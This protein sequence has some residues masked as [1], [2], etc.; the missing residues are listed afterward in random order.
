MSSF[1]LTNHVTRLP[2]IR[3]LGRVVVVYVLSPMFRDLIVTVP[4]PIVVSL[5][6]S[7]QNQNTNGALF[8]R[9]TIPLS[10]ALVSLRECGIWFAS[11]GS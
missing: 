8:L 6:G 9:H 7:A 4:D 1:L 5:E 3:A 2:G 10:N 11:G